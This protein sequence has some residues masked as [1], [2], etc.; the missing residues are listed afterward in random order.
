MHGK[1]PLTGKL[2]D[3][4]MQQKILIIEDDINLGQM[5]SLHFEDDGFKTHHVPSCEKAREAIQHSLYDLILLDQQLPDGLGI[6]LL[7]H[8]LSAD[9]RAPVIMMTGHHDLQ[10]AIQAITKGASDFIHKPIETSALQASVEKV[11]K[12]SQ[13][14]SSSQKTLFSQDE[15]FSRD[16][17][18]KSSA[19]LAVSK[20]IALSAQSNATVLITGESGT[21]KELVAKLIHQHS[22]RKNKAFIAVNCA[23]IVDTLLE[24]ELFGH[25]KGAFTGATE[26]KPGKFELAENGTLFLDEIG[27]LALPLQAKLLRALQEQV[28]EPVGSTQPKKIDV[29]VIAATNRDLFQMSQ[30][31]TFREDLIYR[32]NVINIQ[33]PPLRKR[34]EDIPLLT[35]ALLERAATQLNQPAP[36]ITQDSIDYLCSREWPGN[37]RE[38]NNTLIQAFIHSRGQP[39]TLEILKPDSA[40]A[41]T[42]AGIDEHPN[43]PLLS[44]DE[45]EARHIQKVL[46]HTRG[47]KSNSCKILGISRPALDRKIT[48]YRLRVPE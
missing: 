2:I 33:I 28:I 48:K 11:L 1:Y 22:L 18:G 47:H 5:L 41:Q 36:G 45:M 34:K 14:Q 43:E 16:L 30:D 35:Q 8:L 6:D 15:S 38:L 42:Q 37:V 20:E 29:R 23:A 3:T 4:R 39:I 10:L 17:V 46:D 21:G 25:E 7:D 24:S 31:K 9:H 26:R 32:L 19:M 13:A 44:L 12:I 40:A 27:E